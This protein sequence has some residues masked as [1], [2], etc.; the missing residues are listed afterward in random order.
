MGLYLLNRKTC[1]DDGFVMH[2]KGHKDLTIKVC[3][4]VT[5][6]HGVGDGSLRTAPV[7]TVGEVWGINAVA[8]EE[9]ITPLL[10]PQLCYFHY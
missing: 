10:T 5:E 7:K 3:G 8:D 1:V 9:G 4:P 2:M 6:I